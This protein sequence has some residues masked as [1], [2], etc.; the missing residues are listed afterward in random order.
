MMRIDLTSS[1]TS[2]I[3]K[4][5]LGIRKMEVTIL[6]FYTL[7]LKEN[8]WSDTSSTALYSL[9]VGWDSGACSKGKSCSC[10]ELMADRPN[11]GQSLHSLSCSR[12]RFFV[13]VFERMINI[14]SVKQIFCEVLRLLT[15]TALYIRN[16][17]RVAQSAQRLA[18][19]WTVRG[20]NPGGRE[21]LRICLDRPWDPPSLLYSGYRVFTGGIERSGRDADPSP[22]LAPWSRK[23]RTIPVLLQCAVRPV[24]SLSACTRVHFCIRN[25]PEPLQTNPH[26]FF[27]QAFGIFSYLGFPSD[28]GP[29]S[30]VF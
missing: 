20:S 11:H 28:P 12:S 7:T 15:F 25:K 23:S 2:P 26:F 5:T 30:L 4:S 29:L 14:L 17:G 19:G 10:Q 21:I 6:A 3:H 16:V 9:M 13:F 18:T 27:C 8:D 24:Q 1:R 22:L